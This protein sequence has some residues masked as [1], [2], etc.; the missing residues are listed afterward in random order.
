MGPGGGERDAP[1]LPAV[2]SW[3]R[4]RRTSAGA[5]LLPA[6]SALGACDIASSHHG[7]ADRNRPLQRAGAHQDYGPGEGAGWEGA[8]VQRQLRGAAPGSI[9]GCWRDAGAPRGGGPRPPSCL[10]VSP[11]SA[12]GAA[13]ATVEPRLSCPPASTVGSFWSAGSGWPAAPLPPKRRRHSLTSV[14][15][16]RRASALL[17]SSFPA[18]LPGGDGGHKQRGGGGGHNLPGAGRVL[19]ATSGSQ[20][21]PELVVPSLSWPNAVPRHGCLR[22]RA[23]QHAS[24]PL[25]PDWSINWSL[26]VAWAGGRNPVS[27]DAGSA[28]LPASPPPPPGGGAGGGKPVTPKTQNPIVAA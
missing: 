15:S 24:I 23:C 11:P 20:H 16:S 26:P 17:P 21:W 2:R 22:L 19:G 27:R 1:P 14:L 6:V 5:P 25:Q 18:S 9:R 3:R 28:I 12:L 13:L 8:L 10:L 7:C 4:R